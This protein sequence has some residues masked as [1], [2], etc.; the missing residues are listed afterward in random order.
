MPTPRPDIMKRYREL[1]A[2][3]PHAKHL[4]VAE[5]IEFERLDRI[6]SQRLARLN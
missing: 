1:D 5:R 4:G 3:R 6:V 2:K